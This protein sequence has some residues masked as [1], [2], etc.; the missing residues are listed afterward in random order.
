M[1]SWVL[2]RKHPLPVAPYPSEQGYG[3]S[4]LAGRKMYPVLFQP[5]F[6]KLQTRYFLSPLQAAS[7]T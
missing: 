1:S 5:T 6:L 7:P 2:N 4:A 3:S